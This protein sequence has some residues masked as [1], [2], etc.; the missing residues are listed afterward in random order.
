MQTDAPDTHALSADIA[1]LLDAPAG[2]VGAP[3]LSELEDTLTT[4]Y[5]RAL[6]LEAERDRIERALLD[7]TG[8]ERAK[9]NRRLE[10]VAGE[11]TDLRRLLVP[12]RSRARAVRSLTIS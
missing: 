5:A 1:T 11:L 6:A 3:S 8:P 12:L 4:G 10:R 9:L 2:G 7:A